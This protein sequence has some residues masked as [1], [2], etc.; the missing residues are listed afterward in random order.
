MPQWL[1]GSLVPHGDDDTE[2]RRNSCF[3][4]SQEEAIGKKSRCIEADCCEDQ[5]NAPDCATVNQLTTQR[6]GKGTQTE[7]EI[8]LATGSLTMNTPAG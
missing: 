7:E 4:H 1:F 5:G 3:S 6:V 2:T 8:T